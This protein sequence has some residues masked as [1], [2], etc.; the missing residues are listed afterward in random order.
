MGRASAA[1]LLLFVVIFILTQI[2]SAM[3]LR[4]G[5]IRMRTTEPEAIV[6]KRKVAI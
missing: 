2:R 3:M 4:R 5:Q 6:V 1:A